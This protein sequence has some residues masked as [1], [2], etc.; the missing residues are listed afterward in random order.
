MVA[1]FFSLFIYDY[2]HIRFHKFVA[3]VIFE[4]KFRKYIFSFQI[5]KSFSIS[6]CEKKL[7]FHIVNKWM[8]KKI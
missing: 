8:K 3:I 5:S 6:I 1:A 4:R 2:N 7:K